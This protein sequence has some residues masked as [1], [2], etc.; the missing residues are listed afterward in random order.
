MGK[1]RN[2]DLDGSQSQIMKI[3]NDLENAFEEGNIDT[4]FSTQ[5]NQE[6]KMIIDQ[7]K[8]SVSNIF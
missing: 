6:M 4:V 1:H 7:E 8:V 5:N 3:R 2:D